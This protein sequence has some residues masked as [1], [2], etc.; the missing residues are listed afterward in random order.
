LLAQFSALQHR[1]ERIPFPQLR[2]SS[3]LLQRVP[4]GTLLYISIP[5][6]GDFLSEANTIFHD[7]LKQ[8]PAL[9][10]WWTR[11]Q[12]SNSADLDA[13]VEKL[14]RTSQYLGEEIVIV[15]VNQPGNPGFAAIADVKQ[16]GLDDFLRKQFLSSHSTNGFTVFDESSLNA[17]HVSSPTG[18]GGYALIRPHE[19]VFSNSIALLKQLNAQLNSGASGFASG[20]FGQQIAAAYSRGAGIILA[21][22]V[23]QMMQNRPAAPG[24]DRPGDKAIEN[25][26]LDGVRYLIAEHRESNG[27]P[28]NHL[29]LQFSGTR[30]R[31][32]S[33][34]AAPAPMGS[35]NFITPNAAVAVA[36]LSKAPKEIAADIM[37]MTEPDKNT[38]NEKWRAAEAKL[39]IDFRE[40]LAACLGGE[41][42][43]SLDGPVLP[44]PSWKAVIEVNNSAR[45]EQTLER[46]TESMRNLPQDKEPH[47]V[48]IE[49]SDAG[50]QRFYSMRD[51]TT[52]N[53]LAYYTFADGY[54][55]VAPSRAL[56]LQ[57]L[58]TYASGDSLARSAAFKA[59]LPKDEYDNYS[60]V[61]YQNL[62]PVLAPLLSHFSGESAQALRQ[63]AADARPTAICAWGKDSR[64]EVASDSRLF[65]FDLL[66]L[67]SLI[68]SGNQHANANVRE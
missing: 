40:D 14:H 8:S 65:G 10:Q 46:L 33:W 17:A 50:G 2:Y 1:I 45:L 49:S 62:S 26:G 11:G 24:V 68:D 59:L 12:A 38:R 30:Q 43:L 20:D 18:A 7:Q 54:M 51:V 13:L 42:L 15:G 31:V 32:A 3:N 41:F 66:T 22:D 36:V 47:G 64:I 19:A 63:M 56:L 39:Q 37:T 29:N 60:A 58:Q 53:V 48:A 44:T 27:Q 9:Q 57:A 28:E 5:N 21:A 25:S 55:I 23:H 61:A 4:S 16:D 67:G 34:L 52:G 35:L 6:L